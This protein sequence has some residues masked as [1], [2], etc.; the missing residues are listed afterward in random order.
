M[1]MKLIKRD[2]YLQQ[3]RDV[4]GVPDIKV[5][6]GV[7]RC[8][9]SR[10]LEA[11]ADE[12]RGKYDNA[13]I[14]FVDFS[15]LEFDGLKDYRLLNAYV[16]ARYVP[17]LRNFLFIDE[18]QL[19]PKFELVVN[20]LHASGKYDIYIIGSN[21]FLL[22]SDLAT[23]F[24]GRTCSI[25]VFP[26]SYA[27]YLQYHD[28]ENSHAS[29]DLYMSDGGM[30]GAY[31]YKTEKARLDYIAD[32]Y[33]TLI[34]R[35][36]KQKY[37][38]RNLPL[39]D[40]LSDFLMDNISNPTSVRSL[41]RVLKAAGETVTNVTLGRYIEYLCNAFAFYRVRR[42]DIK[43]K[44][45]LTTNDKYYLSDHSFRYARLGIKNPDYG[46]IL[47]NMV[48][49][50]LLRRGY[51]IY[52]GVLYA[53]EVDFVALR[54][55]EKI[56]IQVAQS[57]EDMNTFKREAAPLLDIKDAYPKF[58]ITRLLYPQYMYEGIKVADISD[59]MVGNL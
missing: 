39:L 22:S 14:I 6:T 36:V 31:L 25:E 38:I 4:E 51:E 27:E 50:E 19:C 20:S 44:R 35:D 21:A 13:N 53:K 43:G 1:D 15:S 49:V 54:R 2:F 3:L 7:R 45:Y 55:D 24:T 30:S 41:A 56:Y 37:G 5:I 28:M 26:F 8:G 48:A 17:E 58:I 40:R 9:K 46:R 29:F 32:V 59:W 10:L 18:V 47:E 23:L 34:L 11:F 16:E 42:Y 52:S 57:I 12:L 33:N